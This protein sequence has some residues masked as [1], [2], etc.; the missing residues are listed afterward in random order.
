MITGIVVVLALGILGGWGG[1]EIADWWVQTKMPNAGL[2]AVMPLGAGLVL[3]A[4]AGLG[5]GIGIA[6]A[7]GRREER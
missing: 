2:E 6:Y 3:G 7:L 4:I 1:Y 5:L